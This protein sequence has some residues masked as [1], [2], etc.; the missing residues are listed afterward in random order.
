MNI[1]FW[2]NVRHQSGVTSCVALLSVLWSELFSEEVA[3][4]SNHICNY[5]L[6]SRLYGETV[7]EEKVA[8]R[9]YRYILGEPEYFRMLYGE[10]VKTPLLLNDSLSYIPMEGD[11]LELFGINGLR[12]LNERKRQ[13]D[14]LFIDTACGYGLCSQKILEEA[15]LAVVLFP[16]SKE[17]IDEFFQSASGLSGNC[18]FVLGNVPKAAFY[19]PSYLTK[20]YDIPEERVGMIPHNAGFE[21]AMREGTTIAYITNHMHC[22]KRNNAYHWMFSAKTT[23][24]RLREYAISKRRCLCGDYEKVQENE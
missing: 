18:F 10:T 2:S 3:V 14:H 6:M 8:Q 16:D 19:R 22:S 15:E 13:E 11:G 20:R 9:A 1:A 5:G 23:V 12:G 21:Q 7:Y 17:C 24:K 4:T